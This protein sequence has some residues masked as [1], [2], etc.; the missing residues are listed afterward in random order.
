MTPRIATI[1]SNEL[2]QIREEAVLRGNEIIFGG[3]SSEKAAHIFDGKI[4]PSIY[5]ANPDAYIGIKFA[6]DY[7]GVLQELSF[8]FGFFVV[9]RVVD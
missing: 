1:K 8:F 5:G 2:F 4:F 3:I 9:D 6:T 7:V